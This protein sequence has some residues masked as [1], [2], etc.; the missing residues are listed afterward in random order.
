MALHPTGA[1]PTPGTPYLPLGVLLTVKPPPFRNTDSDVDH[2]V[3]YTKRRRRSNHVDAYDVISARKCRALTEIL[4]DDQK[5]A[6][7]C[8][9]CL[10]SST[11][12][13]LVPW[14]SSVDRR[15]AR[16]GQSPLVCMHAKILTHKDYHAAIGTVATLPL[17]LAV[18]RWL[19]AA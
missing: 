11:A 10:C 3:P 15:T 6:A 17:H 9:P 13:L 8:C 12:S 7:R 5:D 2:S 1:Y 19:D 18:C 4:P 14:S 16:G